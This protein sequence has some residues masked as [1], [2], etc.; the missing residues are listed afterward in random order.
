MMHCCNQTKITP[1][2][3]NIT[4]VRNIISFSS[5]YFRLLALQQLGETPAWEQEQSSCCSGITLFSH[6]RP[7]NILYHIILSV[8]K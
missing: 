3:V 8:L 1:V 5:I 7:H 2:L 4:L 6:N